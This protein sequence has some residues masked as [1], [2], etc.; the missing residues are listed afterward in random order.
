MTSPWIQTRTRPR[1]R[2]VRGFSTWALSPITTTIILPGFR[3]H[4]PFDVLE[5]GVA[6]A[7]AQ[8]K[9][10]RLQSPRA[11][12]TARKTARGAKS[13]ATTMVA[14]PGEKLSA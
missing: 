4:D 7:F 5:L 12:L 9:E 14:R 11:S 3:L 8:I 6:V 13:A 2:A 1:W 10:G